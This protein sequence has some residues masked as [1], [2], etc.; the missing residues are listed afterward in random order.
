VTAP[1]RRAVVIATIR[2]RT[3][4]LS[5]AQNGA[6][7]TN[8]DVRALAVSAGLK[9]RHTPRTTFVG[10]SELPDL[11]ALCEYRGVVVQRRTT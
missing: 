4:A 5:A 1:V 6:G 10:L 8:T 2:G 3:V 11:E 7:L 9:P